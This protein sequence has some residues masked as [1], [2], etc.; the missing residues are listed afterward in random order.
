MT[1]IDH[2][3]RYAPYTHRRHDRDNNPPRRCDRDTRPRGRSRWSW[4]DP[5][6]PTTKSP[7]DM[8]FEG[9]LSTHTLRKFMSLMVPVQPGRP[10]NDRSPDNN[11]T[12][13]PGRN[14]WY[15][16]ILVKPNNRFNGSIIGNTIHCRVSFSLSGRDNNTLSRHY[17]CQ[18]C[19]SYSCPAGEG[20]TIGGP[21]ICSNLRV[22]GGT[23]RV[24]F[25]RCPHYAST[26]PGEEPVRF[27]SFCVDYKSI[28]TE[29]G[30]HAERVARHNLAKW[31]DAFDDLCGSDRRAIVECPVCGTRMTKIVSRGWACPS[32]GE[33][34]VT[35][36]VPGDGSPLWPGTIVFAYSGPEHSNEAI[37]RKGVGEQAEERP[38]A[39]MGIFDPSPDATVDFNGTPWFPVVGTE[40][41]SGV[42]LARGIIP[43]RLAAECCQDVV[44]AE[45]PNAC[46]CENYDSGSNA[47]LASGRRCPYFLTVAEP[48]ETIV[49]HDGPGAGTSP[50]SFD[51]EFHI[52]GRVGWNVVEVMPW[53][54]EF[55]S[56]LNRFEATSGTTPH[57]RTPLKLGSGGAAACPICDRAA[58]VAY[59]N[60]TR[61]ANVHCPRHGTWYGV[62]ESNA[63]ATLFVAVRHD[64]PDEA[65]P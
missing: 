56:A 17:T 50:A 63:A 16:E 23:C 36:F 46:P 45:S 5:P 13:L 42:T 59:D 19:S 34:F 26:T 39:M 38:M 32:H 35:N 37:R 44:P 12:T 29:E 43:N 3:L 1:H 2:S 7:I 53:A 11:V 22:G 31:D 28:E 48:A 33:T 65:P 64:P 55:I 8:L 60:I 40:N 51:A 61:N 24:S 4:W 41:T 49:P 52:G 21:G 47:C 9:G 62:G 25:A 30:E 15:E 54:A 20:A 10:I 58:I 57:S 6:K 18:S 27:G 14:G